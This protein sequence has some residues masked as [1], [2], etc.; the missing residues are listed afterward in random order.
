MILIDFINYFKQFKNVT[1]ENN[2]ME[3][4]SIETTITI[5]GEKLRNQYNI[6]I[7]NI[8]LH[9]NVKALCLGVKKEI[10]EQ[11]EHMLKGYNYFNGGK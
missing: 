4:I 7:H 1:V 11:I 3:Y 8:F 2:E 9:S 5:N 10:N 6:P